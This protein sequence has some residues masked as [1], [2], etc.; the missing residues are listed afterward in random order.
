[1]LLLLPRWSTV[2][3]SQRAERMEAKVV[4]LAN[5]SLHIAEKARPTP[6]LHYFNHLASPTGEAVA[7]SILCAKSVPSEQPTGTPE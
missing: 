6:E 3:L 4:D 1:M 7:P 2:R 5:A